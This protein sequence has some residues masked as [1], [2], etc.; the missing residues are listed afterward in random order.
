MKTLTDVLAMSEQVIKL[1]TQFGYSDE[2]RLYHDS[3][4]S[5]MSEILQFVVRELKDQPL[6]SY[7]VPGY[8]QAMLADTLGCRVEVIVYQNI[9]NLY[10]DDTD[11]KSALITDKKALTELFGT[12]EISYGEIDGEKG[13]LLQNR[14]LK[15]AEEYL[16]KKSEA[17]VMDTKKRAAATHQESRTYALMGKPA[18]K[19]AKKAKLTLDESKNTVT[20]SIPI[21]AGI[22]CS[23]D[24]I[25]SPKIAEELAEQYVRMLEDVKSDLIV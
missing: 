19:S 9:G 20:L 23:Q 11:Q 25:V 4:I 13:L 2:V 14:L 7:K 8:L 21:P 5:D 12:D 24:R 22:Q 15:H 1:V 17:P 3:P 16:Q 10:R 18:S 6:S